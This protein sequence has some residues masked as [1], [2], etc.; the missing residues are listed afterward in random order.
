MRFQRY[1]DLKTRVCGED[2]GPLHK[3][4][5]IKLNVTLNTM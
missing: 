5:V 2:S 1:K 3:D 4:E